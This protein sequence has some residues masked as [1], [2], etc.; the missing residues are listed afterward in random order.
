[1]LIFLLI[2][3]GRFGGERA[4]FELAAQL[5]KF[6]GTFWRTRGHGGLSK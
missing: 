4:E 6:P 3:V 1:M 5:Q 2:L